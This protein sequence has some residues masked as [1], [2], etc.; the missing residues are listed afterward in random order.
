MAINGFQLRNVTADRV[1]MPR[2]RQ[3]GDVVDLDYQPFSIAR[4]EDAV[5]P[6]PQ[7]P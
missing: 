4:V 3:A 1:D 2:L 5:P 7:A 6:R